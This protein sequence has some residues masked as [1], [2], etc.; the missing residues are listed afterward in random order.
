MILRRYLIVNFQARL[1]EILFLK[2]KAFL[3]LDG[4]KGLLE[5]AFRVLLVVFLMF[6]LIFLPLY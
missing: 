2:N 5:M 3:L 1:K 6:S 4:V